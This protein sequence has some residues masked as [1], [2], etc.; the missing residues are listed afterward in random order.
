[1][2]LVP[3]NSLGKEKNKRQSQ[4]LLVSLLENFINSFDQ[5]P[6]LNSKLF[7]E[8][9]KKL[10][11]LGIIKNEDVLQGIS[12]SST[13]TKIFKTLIV[14][15]LQEVSTPHPTLTQRLNT[16]LPQHL[17]SST[18][19][20]SGIFNDSRYNNEFKEISLLG[21]GGFGQVWKVI[22]KLDGMEYA[23]KKVLIGTV[24]FEKVVREVKLLARLSNKNVVRYFTSW[25]EHGVFNKI[26]EET[27]SISS[28][29]DSTEVLEQLDGVEIVA[30]TNSN[31]PESSSLDQQ[32]ILY[33]QM[34]LCGESLENW[35]TER[36]LKEDSLKT[37]E[38]RDIFFSIV[39]GLE[40]IHANGCIHRDL[41]PLNIFKS[42]NTWKVGDFGL[43]I[44]ID[45][46]IK[47][48]DCAMD[49]LSIGVGTVTY[50]APE[51]ITDSGYT[52]QADIYSL[53]IILFELM[54]PLKTQMERAQVLNALKKGSFPDDFVTAYPKEM[55]LIL[56]LMSEDPN[57]RPT[58]SQ[59]LEFEVLRRKVISTAVKETQTKDANEE[60]DL[61]RIE[62]NMLLEQIKKLELEIEQ[63]KS[64][65]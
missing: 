26:G 15:A 22:N 53:G 36:N 18:K 1:M 6:E 50:A 43:A 60:V 20:L 19:S 3:I 2:N 48:D 11:L 13:Y 49:A 31:S 52:T 57:H 23:V 54:Y 40:N 12:M 39:S 65:K 28:S 41:K 61:L 30:R 45:R 21:T 14:Q 51:T 63:L 42:F 35:I 7:L 10:T 16:T 8:I 5:S 29:L 62:R 47:Q 34:E 17:L 33:I 27:S 59:L 24:D 46:T 38:C 44:S 9:C 56:W 55:A 25:I 64:R 58:A 32:L 37:N 4:L